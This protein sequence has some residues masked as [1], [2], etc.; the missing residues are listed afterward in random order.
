M[1]DVLSMK[2]LSKDEEGLIPLLVGAGV[3]VASLFGLTYTLTGDDPV[4]ALVDFLKALI[5]GI[6]LFVF[7]LL[8]LMKKVPIPSP[9]GLFVGLLSVG[10]GMYFIWSGFAW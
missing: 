10:S 3:V 6:C 1:V 7:G 9:Y 5:V 4:T 8:V 2:R